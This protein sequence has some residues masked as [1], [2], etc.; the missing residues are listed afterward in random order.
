MTKKKL[1][2]W[3]ALHRSKE[4]LWTFNTKVKRDNHKHRWSRMKRSSLGLNGFTFHATLSLSLAHIQG[5]ID[6]TSITKRPLPPPYSNLKRLYCKWN[7]SSWSSLTRLS[8]SFTQRERERETVMLCLPAFYKLR[9]VHRISR[10]AN[11]NN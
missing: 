8:R 5:S 11:F 2:K 3:T 7:N 10:S 1:L 9:F 4:N 6:G